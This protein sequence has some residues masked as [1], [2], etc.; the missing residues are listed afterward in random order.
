MEKG[1]QHKR[2]ATVADPGLGENLWVL[3]LGTS[4][5][6]VDGMWI[7]YSDEQIHIGVLF[8]NSLHTEMKLAHGPK[9]QAMEVMKH[10]LVEQVVTLCSIIG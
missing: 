7:G 3:L 8:D 2:I 5:S 1:I 9:Q 6:R 10:K 4:S